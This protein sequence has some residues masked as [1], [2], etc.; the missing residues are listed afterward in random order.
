MIAERIHQLIQELPSDVELVAISK[1]HPASSIMEAYDAGQRLF[2]ES[3]LQ[4]LKSKVEQLPE[5]IV[6]H[7]IGHLQRNKVKEVIQL[8]DTIQSVDSLRLLQ[9]IQ[10]QSAES[11]RSIN[12]FLQVYVGNEDTKYGL[13]LEECRNIFEKNIHLHTEY[14]KITGLMCMATNTDNEELIRKEF[15]E[16]YSFF[17]Q[18]K[19]DFADIDYFSKLSMGMSHDYQLAIQEGSN[20]VRVGSFIF[21]D[22]TY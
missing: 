19:A 2:G 9:E 10:K 11:K 12:C 3:R 4:E 18:L 7:F 17:K 14:C 21:G 6:W 16:V 20:M 15:R 22:R 8:A 1:F 13:T 5:D